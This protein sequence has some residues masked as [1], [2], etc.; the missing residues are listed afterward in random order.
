MAQDKNKS[1]LKVWLADLTHTGI[2]GQSLG[3]DTFP[4]AI[5]CIAT[6]AE[7]KI[8]LQEPIRLF[9]Y[10]H[11]LAQAFFQEVSPDIIGF[12]NFVWN[13][14]LSL[15]IA[16]R[17]KAYN[18]KLIVVMGGPNYPLERLKQEDFLR[19]HPEIDFYILHEGEEA[20]VNL[21]TGLT[22]AGMDAETIKAGSGMP[23]VQAIDK[24][25]R[26]LP[27]R[28]LAHRLEN[29]DEIPSAYVNG[30]FD[31]F[32]DGRLW[33]LIQT[34]RGCPFSC[35]YCTEGNS[36]YSKVS[37]F[38]VAY[39]R[40]QIEYIGRKMSLVRAQGGRSDLYIGDS[41]FGMYEEDI[42]T[43]KALAR[44]YKLYGWPDHINTST[45]KNQKQRILE[46]ARIVEGRIVL[47]GSVQSLD[48][49]VLDNI[50]RKNIS[51]DELMSLA[52]EARGV[53]AN[54]YCEVIL[55]LPG[56]TRDSHLKTL[57]TVVNSG[58]NKVIPYQ[59]MI[60]S[61]SEL[62][63]EQTR[64]QYGM[65]SR[66][67]VLPRAFGIY[68]FG[69]K[70]LVVAD[71][72][73]TCVAGNAMSFQDYIACRVMHLVITIFYNDTVFGTLMTVMK[74]YEWPI[75]RFLELI[76]EAIPES[77]L[78]GLFNDFSRHTQAELWDNRDK[79]EEFI[80]KPGTIE[81]YVNGQ[82]GFNLLYTFKAYALTH[83][84]DQMADLV[85]SVVRSM[86]RQAKE[87]ASEGEVI[88]DT[89]I[90][91]DAARLANI[92]KN[93]DKEVVETFQYDMNRFVSGNNPKDISRYA[94]PIPVTWK[95][96]LTQEQKDYIR[97]NLKIFGDD[98]GGIG[99]VLSNAHTK[100]L[101]RRPV[102]MGKEIS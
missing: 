95:F 19:V 52:K 89:A 92:V 36:Y 54:S 90:R 82:L 65:Q 61:G 10:P 46:I 69:N 23:S 98:P 85:R 91:W 80:Q 102:L 35:T 75:F 96:V 9:R 33:P 7:S 44:S 71:I 72:E 94:S 84:F 77:G 81:R 32:F 12:S 24:S 45:G 25:G 60:L 62:S 97:R 15:A 4:L 101:L 41:N 31:E 13:S 27:E 79:L 87:C 47:S 78:K 50:K 56:E 55:G 30:K 74:A 39:L 70:D 26:F 2:D 5:G 58:F 38:S 99:R 14:Q 64:R 6:Y 18:P 29:L 22:A 43:A 11:K 83:Y 68:P 93:L 37:Q 76:Q 88:F 63:T 53:D 1:G 57:K 28:G 40:E 48:K 100:Q 34:K 67:R 42:E 73:E 86:C 66:F 21:L 51:A 17:L 20:F 49:D 59:L 16:R 3:V 8:Q